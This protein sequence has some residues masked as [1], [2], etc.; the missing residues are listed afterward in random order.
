MKEAL[1]TGRTVLSVHTDGPLRIALLGT[2]GIPNRYGGFEQISETLA[3][4]L[5]ARGHAVTVYCSGTHPD[6]SPSWQGVRRVLCTD[7][8]E[9][10]G[11]F[12]QFLYDRNCLR[13]AAREGYD[14]LLFLGY[15]SSSV[16]G[17]WFPR[18]CA[19]LSNMDGLEWKRSKYAAP[20]RRFL[21]RAEAWAVRYSHR[22]IADSPV[23]KEYLDARYGIDSVY[24]PYGAEVRRDHDA[25]TLALYG[26]QPDNYYMLMARME[27]ENHVAGILEGYVRSGSARSM[28]VVG[29]AANRYGSI[30][31][32]RF[33]RHTGIRFL[34]PLFDQ[35]TVHQLR[36]QATLY[37]HGHS[38]GGTNPSLLEAMASGAFIAA[39]RNPF[40]SRILGEDGLYF[41]TADEVA[42]L[43][44]EHHETAIRPQRARHQLKI[45]RDYA[46]TPVIDL[47]EQ[48][49]YQTCRAPR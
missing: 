37:F 1:T 45:E 40:N 12:G 32:K 42:Q 34:G 13:H 30:L 2:R 27:P 29:N 44:K 38:V 36:A 22:H 17:P 7:P 6:K 26:L 33:S 23:I 19:I 14:A 21:R 31:R 25:A 15:T 16:W 46:W 8:E 35:E 18:G 39:H 48:V 5:A 49:I 11:T 4:G 43:I 41:T 9:R 28:L 24:I 20:V 10:L 47:Y 3:A